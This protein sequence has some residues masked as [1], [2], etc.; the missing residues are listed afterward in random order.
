M[1][2]GDSAPNAADAPLQPGDDVLVRGRVQEVFGD[3]INVTFD[4]WWPRWSAVLVKRARVTR[5]PIAPPDI[6]VRQSPVPDRPRGG[7]PA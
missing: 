3:E 4:D 7:E 6:C 5:M 1:A 2:D